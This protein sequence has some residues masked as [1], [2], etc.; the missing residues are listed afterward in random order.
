[1]SACSHIQNQFSRYLDG[2]VPGTRMLEISSHLDTCAGCA[3]EFAAWQKS[4]SLVSH[5]W[6]H[7]GP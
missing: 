2:D 4:Q 6:P 1:M 3:R 7:E 5:S